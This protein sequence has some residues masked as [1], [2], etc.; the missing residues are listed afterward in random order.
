MSEA[1]ESPGTGEA[2]LARRDHELRA[3]F[4]RLRALNSAWGVLAPFGLQDDWRHVVETGR[5][6]SGRL[7]ELA[8]QP[9]ERRDHMALAKLDAL[10][11]TIESEM[12]GLA[13]EVPVAELRSTLPPRLASERRGVLDLLDLMLAAEEAEQPGL[14]G[15]ISALDYLITLLCTGG[16]RVGEEASQD[17]VGLT[18]RLHALCERA[19]A[20]DD[21]R[22]ADVEA[23]FREAAD[24]AEEDARDEIRLRRLRRRKR[25]LGPSFFAPRVLRAIVAYNSALSRCIDRGVWDSRDWGSLPGA[26]TASQGSASVFETEALPR[27]AEALRRRADGAPPT[28]SAVDR[29]AWCLDIASLEPTERAALLSPSAGRAGDLEGTTVLVGLLSASA[30]VLEGELPGIGIS[31]ESLAD[32]WVRELDEVLRREVN[33]RIASDA[34]QDAC[35]LSELRT[36]FLYSLRSESRREPRRAPPGPTRP[37]FEQ[38]ARDARDLAGEALVG[39]TGPDRVGGAPPWIASRS[40][41]RALLAKRAATA[42]VAALALL[43]LGRILLPGDDLEGWSRAELERVSPFLSDGARNEHGRGPAFVGTLDDAWLRLA[44]PQQ[45]HAARELVSA[46]RGRGVQQVMVYDDER[47]LRIQAL[48]VQPVRVLPARDP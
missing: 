25:E 28:T 46:L 9:F 26:G 45:E 34:Y 32:G 23:E 47:R 35:A 36:R 19:D 8:A 40:W 31:P 39:E 4:E 6:V 3:R 16:S 43:G 24:V 15:R 37:R 14:A 17:P 42:A 7:A 1:N 41:S 2:W 12:L 18:P 13:F 44:P 33:Q 22:L 5:A 10:L 27:L 11:D 21:P 20:D 29:V 38:V 30:V 48:G